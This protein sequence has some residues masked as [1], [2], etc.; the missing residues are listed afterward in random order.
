MEGIALSTKRG[1]IIAGQ[2]WHITQRCHERQFLLNLE[3]DRRRWLYWL[4]QL[5]QMYGLRVLNYVV[6]CNH[7]HL[8]VEG[9]GTQSL[10]A[11]MS[12]INSRTTEEFNRRHL[13]TGR[14]WEAE[15]QVTAI[16]TDAHLARCMNYIDMHMVRAG[17]VE[18]PRQWRC[19]GYHESKFHCRRGGRIDHARIRHLL[20]LKS[21]KA[22]LKARDGWIRRKLAQTELRREPYWS[23]S[24]AVGDLSFALR[25]KRAFAYTHPGRHAQ[26]E[27]DCYALRE[28]RAQWS[29]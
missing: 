4:Y 8:L 20:Q 19:S 5:R 1:H 10:H 15:Y 6:T 14:V 11:C 9:H 7:I 2:V 16:Q 23:N 3:S 18:H 13:R 17:A 26:R 27:A 29:A 25:M 24:I 22:L 12:L 21:D 28:A